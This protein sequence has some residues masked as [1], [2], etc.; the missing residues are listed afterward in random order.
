[1][2][3]SKRFGFLLLAGLFTAA[4]LSGCGGS[5]EEERIPTTVTVFNQHSIVFGTNS[6]VYTA[7]YNAFGQLGDNSRE[8]RDTAVQVAGLGRITGFAAGASHT[9]AFTNN[10][11]AMA[12]GFNQFGQ[13]GTK[14]VST[15]A[16]SS[17]TDFS[18]IPV[19]VDG[20]NRVTSVAAG[21]VHSLAVSDGR[22]FS[23]GGNSF[24]QLG[25]TP[26]VAGIPQE[27]F[28]TATTPFTNVTQV[29]AG[30]V[31]SLV[32]ADGRVWA[33]G[34]NALGELGDGPAAVGTTSSQTPVEV[35]FAGQTVKQIA[36]A[37]SFSVALLNNGTVWAWGHNQYG[38]LGSTEHVDDIL[39]SIAKPVQVKFPDGTALVADEIAAGSGHVLARVGGTVWA[40]GLNQKGQLGNNPVTG[41]TVVPKSNIPVQMLFG[42]FEGTPNTGDPITGVLKVQ[43]F[44]ESSLV[45][46]RNASSGELEVWGWGDNSFGQLGAATTSGF[47]TT[48][49]QMQGL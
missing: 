23:W 41:T 28:Q 26:A 27:V 48:P 40:W 42:G 38:Q 24:G 6:S 25:N 17:T 47:R 13:L 49:I 30:A 37:G 16:A 31:H 11:T 19:P 14:K 2:T 43:A 1:M 34:D 44:G 18:Q 8:N 46:L 39:G 29:A 20:L 15:G 32:L 21:L 5:S 22:V 35:V 12:W 4:S 45:T 10:S 9:L 7:G 36:A 3:S 33:W